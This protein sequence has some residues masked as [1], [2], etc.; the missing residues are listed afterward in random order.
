MQGRDDLDNLMT[1]LLAVAEAALNREGTF[2][3]FAARVLDGG[4]LQRMTVEPD[5]D[6]PAPRDAP[7]I[8]EAALAR[9]ARE[10]LIR[11]AGVC[12]D[13]R[14]RIDRGEARDAVHLALEH[15]DGGSVDAFLP[16]EHDGEFIVFGE[17]V[18]VDRAPQIF[19]TVA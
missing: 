10:G 5:S 2:Y 19:A 4:Q 14:M 6:M 7:G 17:V 3:P 8:L 11:A 15:R 12:T 18:A 1:D 16:Y 13:V 9:E